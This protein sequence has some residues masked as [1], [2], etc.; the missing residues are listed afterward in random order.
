MSGRRSGV[1]RLKKIRAFAT[2]A[3]A[4]AMASADT[5]A[6][7]AATTRIPVTAAATAARPRTSLRVVMACSS[8][9]PE[10]ELAAVVGG[11]RGDGDIG[12]DAGIRHAD[13]RADRAVAGVERLDQGRPRRRLAER[14]L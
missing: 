12:G 6:A 11:Q 13:G 10:L 1:L 14:D 7:V 3:G 4:I 5:A 8:A 9:G 2:G